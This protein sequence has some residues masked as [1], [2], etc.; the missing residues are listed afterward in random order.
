MLYQ[1]RKELEQKIA[2]IKARYS[3][4]KSRSPA[5]LCLDGSLQQRNCRSQAAARTGR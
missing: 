4:Q 2:A 3:E 5:R 1:M